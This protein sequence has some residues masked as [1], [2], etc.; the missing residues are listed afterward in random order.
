MESAETPRLVPI[1]NGD[2][3]AGFLIN[4]GPRGVEAFDKDEKSLGVFPDAPSAAAAVKRTVVPAL[5]PPVE[6]GGMNALLEPAHSPFGGSVAARVLRCPAS[7]GLSEKVPAYLRKVS[8]YAERGVAL[9]SIMALLIEEKRRIDDLAGETFN[10]YTLTID[11]VENALRPAYAY[12]DALL[13]TPGAEFYLEHRVIFPT[14][15]G[16]FGTADLVARIGDTIHVIDFKFGA[17]VR[18][19]ALYPDGDEDVINSQL[20]VYGAA[21]RHSIP[22]FF[23][24]VENIVLTVLQPV[25]IEPDAEMVSSVTITHAE[26][27]EFIAVYRAACE[28]ALSEAPRQ[29]RGDW[30]RFCAAKPI[31]P[32]HTKPLLDL[33]R[34]AELTPAL[35]DG[36]LVA[37]SK[38]AYLQLLANG[39]NFFEAVKELRTTLHD[40]A[41]RALES[42]DSVPGYALTAGRAVR[43]WRDEATA[44]P[45]LLK[46]GLARDDVLVEELRSPKQVETRAKARGIKVPKELIVS[47]PSGVSLVRSENAHAP[48]LGRDE[49]VR[50]FSE[51]LNAFQKG[52][53]HAD[54]D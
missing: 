54:Q 5:S 24:G 7:V 23:A 4:L 13:A 53:N 32:E 47:H 26:L 51:A 52:S 42:G 41:K 43:Q 28:E 31:C 6:D 40:Q 11:D 48:M 16:A 3:C 44:A 18:V 29:E 46:L 8:A 45:D 49:S 22:K 33:G 25:S 21:T 36:A 10:N 14:V 19:L 38:E 30:C 9:H 20:M 37:P 50:S 12:V 1:M 27:D 17:G 34:F 39:L 15:D 35:A 2:A